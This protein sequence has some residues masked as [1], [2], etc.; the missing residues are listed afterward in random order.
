M[1]MF[2]GSR[3]IYGKRG[4]QNGTTSEKGKMKIEDEMERY[5]G[6]GHGRKGVGIRRYVL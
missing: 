6:E 4:Y 1:G 3:R 5:S 2:K